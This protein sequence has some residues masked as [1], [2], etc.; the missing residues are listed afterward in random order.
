MSQIQ[1]EDARAGMV[2]SSDVSAKQT[3]L[4]KSGTVLS[5]SLLKAFTKFGVKTIDVTESDILPLS[6]C[7]MSTSTLLELSKA[8]IDDLVS[9]CK[10]LVDSM[11]ESK[12]PLL[13]VLF[14]Y[15][16][17]T[18]QHS[19]NVACL[20]T[21]YAIRNEFDYHQI[22]TLALGGLLHDIGKINIPIDIL[23]KPA[24]LSD[25]EFEI[26]KRHPK[27]GYNMLFGNQDISTAIK[28]IVYQHHEN[29]DGSGYPRGL[30]HRSGYQLAQLIHICDVYEAL[31]AERPYKPPLPRRQVRS[32]MQAGSGTQF[33]PRLLN[34][35]MKCIPLYLAGEIL[36]QNGKTAIV[37]C[38]ESVE[39][40]LVMYNNKAIPLSDFEHISA[41]A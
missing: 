28:Q 6:I 17:G 12:E 18:F 36:Y 8:N 25:E 33:E 24:K 39:N 16:A 4:C 5:A 14:T 21:T 30:S 15:D 13:E 9:Q 10:L 19:V 27:I 34:N 2:L 1:V 41:T 20:A 29:F 32:I 38:N 37:I 3:L 11:L 23:H 31:C 26:I 7:N 22:Y 40:P 35:F